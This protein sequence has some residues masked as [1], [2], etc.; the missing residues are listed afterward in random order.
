MKIAGTVLAIEAD[1]ASARGDWGT[2]LKFPPP[3]ADLQFRRDETSPGR[4]ASGPE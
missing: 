1:E 4:L 3:V 2:S